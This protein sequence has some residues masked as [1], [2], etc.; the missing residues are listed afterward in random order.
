MTYK[1]ENWS[2]ITTNPYRAPELGGQMIHGSV[3]GHPKF[4]DGSHITTSE[5]I[6]RKGELLETYSGSLYELGSI[7]PQYEKNFPNA[8]SR[9]MHSL[10]ER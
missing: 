10:K 2:I 3:Y 9:I 6:G 1:M 7:D 5:I 8:F 4:P